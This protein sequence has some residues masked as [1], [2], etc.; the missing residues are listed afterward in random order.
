MDQKSV[1]IVKKNW[2][3]VSCEE[4]DYESEDRELTI[5]DGLV[6]ND[7]YVMVERPGFP[8]ELVPMVVARDPRDFS[9]MMSPELWE[10]E[11][12]SDLI[13]QLFQ[14]EAAAITHELGCT[15][16]I[17]DYNDGS[18]RY[19]WLDISRLPAS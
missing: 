1:D 2:N 5:P 18:G 7:G 9:E 17:V 12:L 3:L 16:C 4:V 8:E 15:I 10:I 19:D 14:Q 13:H 6:F 11:E